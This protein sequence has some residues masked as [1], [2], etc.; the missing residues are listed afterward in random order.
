LEALC[1]AHE[2]Y[3]IKGF[4]DI[5]GKP[6]RMVIQGVG[7]RFETYFDRPWKPDEARQSY[8]VVIGKHVQAAL[9]PIA[10]AG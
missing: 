10:A 4:L 9:Q 3:R 1:E 5:P 2:I 8:V 7:K 6:M